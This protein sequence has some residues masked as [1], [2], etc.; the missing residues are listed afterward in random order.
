ML[1]ILM[2]EIMA[3]VAG[4]SLEF[5]R[6]VSDNQSIKLM[7]T[8]REVN[9][10]A[11][12]LLAAVA[13]LG[14]ATPALATSTRSDNY[15]ASE[16][17]FG[18]GAAL[19][20]CSGSY[21][22]RASIGNLSA[23]DSS[24]A[25]FTAAFG[26]LSTDSEPMLDVMVEPGDANLGV[27]STD[28]TASRS[29]VLH[30]RS[31]L[32]GGYQIQITGDPPR[33]GEHQLA[34]PSTPTASTPGTEQFA[35][36]AVANTAPAVGSDPEFTAGEGETPDIILS[37]YATANSYMYLDGDV[38]ARTTSES[39]QISYTISMIV[40]VAGSTPAGNYMGDFSAIVTPVF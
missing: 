38:V 12:W 33:Y 39:S 16:A 26:P 30:V 19:E 11:L 40:N 24:S 20:A 22:A 7:Q 8:H 29:M 9:W 3:A 4:C 34:T 2:L 6:S 37:D 1:T 25:S 15:E 5:W 13:V 23:D 27:L 32:A 17:E 10:V 31:Y 18:A 36:N 21:C 14:L 28:T 35:I